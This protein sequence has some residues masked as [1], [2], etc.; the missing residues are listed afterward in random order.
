[1]QT[2]EM[3]PISEFGMSGKPTLGP[4]ISVPIDSGEERPGGIL[5][6]R[7]HT[8]EFEFSFPLIGKAA[9]D[10]RAFAEKYGIPIKPLTYMAFS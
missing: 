6:M 10:F 4:P 2:I 8:D 7:G 1:M 3:N 5:V 9:A